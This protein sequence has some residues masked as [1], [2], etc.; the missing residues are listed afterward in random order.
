MNNL[1][2][3]KQQRSLFIIL[4]IVI[5]AVVGVSVWYLRF[6]TVVNPHAAA[7]TTLAFTT[8]TQTITK[9]QKFS[10][11]ITVDPGTNSISVVKLVL[12]YNSDQLQVA[13]DA[14]TLVAN[15]TAFP[16]TLQ[17]PATT[18]N[19]TLCTLTATL[20]IGSD[21]TR[22]ITTKTTLAT[23][24]ATAL[25]AD[26]TSVTVGFD[27]ST[28]VYSVGTGDQAS[29]NV[30]SSTSPLIFT[31]NGSGN[32]NG[33]T[34]TPTEAGLCSVNTS[35]CAWDNLTSATSYH[36][37]ITD[38]TTGNVVSEGDLT[39]PQ[40][41]V[42]FSQVPGDNYTCTVTAANACKT[43]SAT[44]V[45]NTCPAITATPT[46]SPTPTTSP[47]V[48]PTPLPSATP[49]PTAT[50]EPSKLACNGA[51]TTDSNCTTGLA[52]IGGFCRNPSCSTI[53]SCSCITPTS[54]PAP[55]SPPAQSQPQQPQYIAAAPTSTP[56]P[57][58]A[59]KMLP[60][61]PGDTFIKVGIIGA[62]IALVGGL[63]IF[64]L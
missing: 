51:C 56:I 30:L 7:S 25:A 47:T 37:K 5:L 44:T 45:S 21:P 17:A 46:L 10:S 35:T 20:A 40:A 55:T 9:G 24:N 59:P 16:Q 49:A 6:Q 61:G 32:N 4:G 13:S 39:P 62:A 8:P 42:N 52:C 38:K 36:Y 34:P 31:I 26:Q 11:D 64:G 1:T 14:S 41:S 18:C 33:T 2:Q 22:A 29:E 63:L 57:T 3:M 53:Y 58:Q 48:T 27:Q 23:F 28:A 19:G 50:P 43:D 54:T 12:T 60:T 15:T